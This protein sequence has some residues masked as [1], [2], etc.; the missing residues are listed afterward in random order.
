[1]G[2]CC[3]TSYYM[4]KKRITESCVQVAPY[5][6]PNLSWTKL[7]SSP[8]L[9]IRTWRE[10]RGINSSS[11]FLKTGLVFSTMGR[12]TSVS[13]KTGLNIAGELL[14]WPLPCK[15]PWCLPSHG[16]TTTTHTDT[17]THL[18]TPHKATNIPNSS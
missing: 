10:M 6:A 18:Y 5:L 16:D 7:F 12:T 11:E 15:L 4:E 17:H 3:L 14:F 13:L 8:N 2:L 9:L 1:M